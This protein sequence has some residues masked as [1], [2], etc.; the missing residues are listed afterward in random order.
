MI[1]QAELEAVVL[2]ALYNYFQ[3]HSGSLTISQI[4]RLLN[5]DVSERRVEMA[6]SNLASSGYVDGEYSYVDEN[7]FAIS[8]AG[9]KYAEEL[10]GRANGRKDADES[11]EVPASDRVVGLDHNSRQF[12][13][14]RS[15]VTSLA[16]QISLANDV[17]NL[18]SREKLVAEQEVTALGDALDRE[19]I[20]PKEI[21]LRSKLT[22]QWIGK[23]AA[24]AVIGTAALALLAL[25]AHLLGFAI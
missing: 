23:E 20:R 22:L 25:I 19:F 5:F 1:K 24:A 6:V 3:V 4:K 12:I 13:E 18:S 11:E 16:K 8:D 2:L 15:E 7:G 9:Y 21:W 14:V 17:G 10:E